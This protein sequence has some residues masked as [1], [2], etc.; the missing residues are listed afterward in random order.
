MSTRC[1]TTVLGPDGEE[2]LVL[3][4]QCDGYP[5]AHG[6]ELAEFLKGRMI[7]DGV[8]PPPVDKAVFT[9]EMVRSLY[10][11]VSFEEPFLASAGLVRSKTASYTWD[12]IPSAPSSALQLVPGVAAVAPRSH[13]TATRLHPGFPGV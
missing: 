2:I 5:K 12:L 1:L 10:G 13:Q 6:V 8:R 11:S 4:R 9:C 7:V 3:Y